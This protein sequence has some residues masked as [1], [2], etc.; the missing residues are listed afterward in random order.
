VR[1][2]A[3]V[4]QRDPKTRLHVGYVPGFTGTHSQGETPR[5]REHLQEVIKMLLEDGEPALEGALF[6]AHRDVVRQP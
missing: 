6:G 3:A 1:A 5:L 4:I 2:F